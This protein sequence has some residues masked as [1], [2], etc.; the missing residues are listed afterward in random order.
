M[1]ICGIDPGLTGAI[2]MRDIATGA[3][4][5]YDMPLLDNRV[6][7]SRFIAIL[8]KSA[9][10]HVYLERVNGMPGQS[11]PA[12]FNFGRGVGQLLGALETLQIPVTEVTSQQW[13]G[14]LKVPRDKDGARLRATQLMPEHAALWPLKKH[15]G[16][17]EAA[18][19][20]FYGCQK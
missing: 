15:D 16:R 18:L 14:V 4:T 3:L 1:V 6:A 10:G 20:A 12:A 19:I 5:V 8:R 11:A 9:P 7:V 17:A 2:A 13:K